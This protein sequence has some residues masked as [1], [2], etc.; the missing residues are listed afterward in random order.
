MSRLYISFIFILFCA[1]GFSQNLLSKYLKTA[2][3]K[4][5]AGDYVYA[6][7]LYGKAMDI[8]SNTIDILW[9]VAEAHAAYKDYRKAEY[10]YA[11]VYDREMAEIY[12][13]SLL[14]LGLM[15]KQNGNYDNAIET[16]K[17][18]KKKYGKN[19]KGYLYLKSRQ[20][21]ESTLWAKSH[22]NIVEKGDFIRLPETVNT[23]NSE[24]GHGIINNTLVFSSL[25]A[26]SISENEEVY[27]K[28]YTTNIFR[29]TIDESRFTLAEKWTELY[30]ENQNT[31]NGSLSLDGKRLYFSSCKDVNGTSYQCKILVAKYM[32]DKW[33]N[34][35]TLG[36]I[37]NFSGS[38]TT[39]PAV[40]QMDG[41]EVLFFV[42]DNPKDSKGGLDI[43]YSTITNGNQ[44]GKPKNLK[45]LNTLDNDLTPFWDFDNNRLYFSSTWHE[46]FGGWDVFYTDY[47]NGQFQEI[48]NAGQP[49]NS[50]ANDL[51]F[52]KNKDTSYVTSNRIGVLYSKNITCCS[53]IFALLPVEKEI[54]PSPRE[55]L[56]EL[57][58]RLPVTL[59]FH[60]DVPNPKSWDTLTTLNYLTTYS[61]YTEMLPRYQKEY[62]TGL[63]ASK[64]EEAKEDIEDFFT[65][66]VDQGVKDLELF[67]DLLLEELQKGARVKIA[68]RGFASPLAKTDYNVNLTKRRISSLINYLKEYDGGVFIPFIDGT[69]STK[70]KVVFEYI[71]FGEYNA[72]QLI[73]DN[74]NDTKNSI[75]SRAAAAE[76]K[77]EIQSISYLEPQDIFPITIVQ[78]VFNAGVLN[79]G[80]IINATFEIK[81]TSENRTIKLNDI[82]QPNKYTKV[83]IN[84]SELKPGETQQITVEMNT[85]GFI[86]HSVK[87]IY[88]PID[89]YEEQVRLMISMELR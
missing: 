37:I 80:A 28:H 33:T 74:P 15:Q 19:K 20:E 78:P 5:Q 75:Y 49:I 69:D 66:H 36:E 47:R 41:Q 6:L 72:N 9:K 22:A 14:Q 38:N 73:S 83:S 79:S 46:G 8:D 32:N 62:A 48:Q 52:F 81:N 11:K 29:S 55:T 86:G 7:E 51:Y 89:G 56:E 4:Y 58:K 65:E 16:F 64:A 42:S 18:A 2:D 3:E 87:S 57:N 63:N 30:T 84:D 61:E 76:R 71:P 54:P 40:G 77:I 10:Y 45:A 44:Y 88:I 43:Y 21:L 39:M 82:S 31:G 70:G 17:K 67:R 27:E 35:D 24:F 50:P 13:S 53:D 25:R 68:V 1:S 34:I 26:D 23:K 59:Y 60:N 85:E 12:P